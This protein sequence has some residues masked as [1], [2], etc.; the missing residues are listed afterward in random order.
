[1]S[2]NTICPNLIIN[3]IKLV[4]TSPVQCWTTI[5]SENKTAK[6]LFISLAL[7]TLVV[8]TICSQ[9]GL[10]IFGQPG[11]LGQWHP[12]LSG[13][14]SQ[15]VF[16]IIIGAAMPF[17][18]AWLIEKLASFF[19]GKANYDRAYGWIIH[20]SLPQLVG[21]MLTIF[22]PIGAPLSILFSIYALYVLYKGLPS[23]LEIPITQRIPFFITY[24][25]VVLLVFVGVLIVAA[26]FMIQATLPT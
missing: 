13:L 26:P 4:I 9:L 2:T 12:S 10:L 23:M 3:R 1:M 5:S 19:Q 14:L 22:P 24:L 20:A 8:A 21:T 7:P 15:G 11:L 16:Q 18:L 25:V 17:A 6:E